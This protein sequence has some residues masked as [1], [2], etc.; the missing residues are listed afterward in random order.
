MEE[1]P[2]LNEE[3]EPRFP[4]R[5][6]KR[7]PSKSASPDKSAKKN[8]PVKKVP[9]GNKLKEGMRLYLMKRWEPALKALL[10]VDA[11]GFTAEE[12]SELAYYLGLCCTKLERYDDALL[13]LEQV[14]T[15]G[16]DMLRAYQ[17]RMT[18]SYIYIITGRVKLAELEL[19]RLHSAGFESTSLYNTMAY[20]SYSQR[21]FKTAIEYYQKALDLDKDN[22]TALNSMGYILA[23]TGLDTKKGLHCCRR[24]LE[25]KP[26]NAAYLDSLGWACYKNRELSEAR[27]LLRRA[28]DAAPQ[29][30]EIREHYRII[31]GEA[32]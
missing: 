13:Y 14:V 12:R 18:L 25:L 9:A 8:A 28:I 1:K 10:L 17:C 22:A 3:F 23:D 2:V 6:E 30:K 7:E 21:H 5:A 31:T 29:E 32:V 16:S 19:K 11:E 20:A 27:S 4:A 15:T 26:D 24:A